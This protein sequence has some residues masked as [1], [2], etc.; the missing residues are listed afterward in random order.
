LSILA[1][2]QS[3]GMSEGRRRSIVAEVLGNAGAS[4][5]RR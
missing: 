1:S 5:G 2:L 3:N 4:A